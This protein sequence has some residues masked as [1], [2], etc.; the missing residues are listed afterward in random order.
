MVLEKLGGSLK[1]TL[2]KIAKAVFVDERLINELVREI[3]RAL[4]GSD[5][6]VK[7]VF[8]LTKK[9][10]ER[11]L[12]DKVPAGVTQK[13]YLVKVVYEELIKFLGSDK[14]EIKIVKKKPFKIMMVGLFGS[15]KCVHGESNIPLDTGEIVKAKQFYERY[16]SKLKSENIN[17]GQIID[18]T[19]EK[20]YVPSF[21]PRTAKIEKKLV[22]HLWKLNKKELFEIY[23]DNGNDFSIKVTPEHP[24]FVL[25]DGIITK[26]KAEELSEDDFVAVPREYNIVGKKIS[27][28]EDL[29]KLNLFTLTNPKETK[30][31]ILDKYP[32][33]K[34][35]NKSLLFARN[36]CQFIT[37]VKKGKLPIQFCIAKDHSLIIQKPNATNEIKIPTTLTKELAEFLGY[38]IGDGNM[39]EKS[40]HIT[41]ENKEIISRVCELSE[42]LFSIK[43]KILKDKRSNNLYRVTLSSTTLIEVLKIF[44]LTPGKKGRNLQ[45]PNQILKSQDEIIKSFLRAY[46]DC[47]A[48]TTPTSREIEISSE[49]QILIEQTGLL[50]QRLGILSTRSKK[51]INGIYY[52]RLYIRARY[53][54]IYSDKIGFLIEYKQNSVKGYKKIGIKQGCGKQDMVPLG[55]LLQEIRSKKGMSIGEI[56]NKAV[57][58]YG[59][60]EKKGIISRESLLKLSYYYTQN[61]QGNIYHFL[62]AIDQGSEN[63][64][65]HYFKN[66]IMSFLIDQGFVVINHNEILLTT[67]A[68]EYL[69]STKHD[70]KIQKHILNLANSNVCWI[71]IKEIKQTKNNE[72]F[73]YDLTVEGNHSFIANG[74]IVHNTTSISKL[75][76]YYFNRGY[77]VGAVGLDVHRAA[78]PEQLKQLCE[79]VKIDCFI[80]KQEKDA[81]KIYKKFEKDF[82]KYDLLLVDTAGRDA[83]SEDLITEI[84]SLNDYI[85]PDEKLLVISAD[86]GQTAQNQA[87]AFHDAC[88]VTGVLVSKLDG[89]AKGGGALSACAATS[90]Q[91]KFIGVGEK[92]EDL[93][94][95]NPKGFVG[96]L[97]GMGDI[98]ALLEKAEEA[99]DKEQA[100]DL[101]KRMLKG[102]FNFL[103]LY[104]QMQAMNKMGSLSK[105]TEM[106]PGFGKMKIP[107]D[108]LEGQEDKLKKW[109]FILGSMTKKELEDPEILDRSRIER[110]ASGAGVETSEV[111]E[112]LKQYK[113]SKKMMKMMKGSGDP[114]KLMKK[115]KGKMPKGF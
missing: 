5:V 27:L 106:L 71:G 44:N 74:I 53:A 114:E 45:I 101:G 46:F 78:A 66:G 11:A 29:K 12:K 31:I 47:D 35:A 16:E 77:K 55:N 108:M 84:K 56:Q 91:V 92:P 64:Y 99:F 60:Y 21:N 59:N 88:G 58:S 54:E 80:D 113:Q 38:L 30:R 1:N 14:S 76:K 94:V 68:Q 100:E 39:E 65:S 2:S 50:L 8:E 19:N 104:D 61:Q 111:R 83:L 81:L 33:L 98:E 17:D 62:K 110:V 107:K 115:F 72:K 102:D 112:L 42:F 37:D 49:S 43:S 103:D 86:I 95:F 3:Q 89:T 105:I 96:R 69:L 75:A 109:K 24:F 67:K 18:I 9:I 63:K 48:H 20:I 87:Q 23:L 85:K 28:F 41:S 82:A 51:K 13:E 22:T 4:L 93:E 34:E 90:A 25:R 10:K 40:I 79:K 26:I 73:V 7:L 97:L 52:W 36:Y 32:T 70:E 57:I 15:G 6:N